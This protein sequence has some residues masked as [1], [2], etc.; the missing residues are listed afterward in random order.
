[1]SLDE[2]VIAIE[3]FEDEK[4]QLTPEQEEWYNAFV[5]G[6]NASGEMKL[7]SELEGYY[8]LHRKGSSKRVVKFWSVIG[9]AAMLAL[10]GFYLSTSSSPSTIKLQME[11]API[12]SDSARYDSIQNKIKKNDA[13]DVDK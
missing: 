11:E 13:D 1:M 4:G 10:G 6:I 3:Q 2:F 12:F 5:R 8:D 9:V 7:K